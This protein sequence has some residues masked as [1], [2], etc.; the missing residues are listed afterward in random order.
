ME[1]LGAN[2]GLSLNLIAEA[3]FQNATLIRSALRLL[4]WWCERLRRY[5]GC[6]ERHQV[7]G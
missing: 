6:A 2:A 5:F 7:G 3:E 4:R 1:T